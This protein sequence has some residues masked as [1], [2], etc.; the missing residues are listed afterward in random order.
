MFRAPL[1]PEGA[2]RTGVRRL[3]SL[4]KPGHSKAAGIRKSLQYIW[5]PVA[6]ISAS[7]APDPPPPPPLYLAGL[8]VSG[9]VEIALREG[10]AACFN[11]TAISVSCRRHSV[12]LYGQG[13]YEAAIDLRGRN[14]QSGFFGLT[15]WHDEDQRALFNLLPELMRRGW[16]YCYT[17]NDRAG[18]QAI[19]THDGERVKIS[20]DIS[21]FGKRRIRILPKAL[22]QRLDGPCIPDH[23]LSRFGIYWF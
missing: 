15:L 23:D 19:F 7:C 8:P 20:I 18:D 16:H 10:F 14:G 2:Q 4:A 6:L 21:Y 12:M 9:S 11:D 5:V 17:G 1:Q 3:L 13:P 22:V